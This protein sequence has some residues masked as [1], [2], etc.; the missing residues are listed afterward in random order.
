MREPDA[1]LA[2]AASQL[3]T[4][5]ESQQTGPLGARQLFRI[6]PLEIRL[7]NCYMVKSTTTKARCP[8]GCTH[9]P[10]HP[11]T[12]PTTHTDTETDPGT[13]TDTG[14]HT[15]TKSLMC[16][17]LQ[18]ESGSNLTTSFSCHII[19]SGACAG[20]KGSQEPQTHIRCHS[21]ASGV[22]SR[23]PSHVTNKQD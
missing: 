17:I 21:G 1:V 9:A 23:G 7:A 15:H 10:A 6:L 22:A 13:D 3:T 19:Y 11:T 20:A 12:P 5:H 4:K 2:I 8:H 16:V 14:T 18:H